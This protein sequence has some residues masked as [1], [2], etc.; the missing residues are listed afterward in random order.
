MR[1]AVTAWFTGAD[2][3]FLGTV[4][5]SRTQIDEADYESEMNA[6]AA[7]GS[8]AVMV[9]NLPRERRSRKALS[10]WEFLQDVAV[11]SVALEIFFA[12]LSGDPVAAQADHDTLIDAVVARIRS[13]PSLGNSQVVWAAAE[14]D[15]GLSVDQGAPYTDDDATVVYIPAV[16]RFDAWEWIAAAAGT[17]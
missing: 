3:P 11:H 9:V 4:Y 7:N 13:S 8:G 10:G 14:G 15:E 12:T 5:P 16:V 1:A 2:L 6:S 17:A